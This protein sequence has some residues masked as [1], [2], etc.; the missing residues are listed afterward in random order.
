MVDTITAKTHASKILTRYFKP[1]IVGYSYG[2]GGRVDVG[3]SMILVI[4]WVGL[5]IG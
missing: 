3:V 2:L 1:I 4:E 5:E